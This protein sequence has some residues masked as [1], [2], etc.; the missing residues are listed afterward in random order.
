VPVPTVLEVRVAASSDDAEEAIPSGTITLT[1][2]DLEMVR[3][4]T[5]QVIGMR[6]VGVTIP[7]G[8]TITRAFIQFT[9]DETDGGTPTLLLSGVAA[10]DVPTFTSVAGNVSSRPRTSATVTWRPP[11]W[12]TVGLAG[13]GQQTSELRP[14]IQE[15]VDRPGWVSGNALAIIVTGTGKRTAVAWNNIPGSAPLLHV[16]YTTGD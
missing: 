6:F 1:S 7:P 8:A 15:I 13:A 14:V 12:S 10:D 9:V 11:S 4:A 2:P 5:D 16:E 3:D